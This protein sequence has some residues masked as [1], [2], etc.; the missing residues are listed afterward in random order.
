MGPRRVK[1]EGLS[2]AE[3]V[4]VA[5]VLFSACASC[6]S[7]FWKSAGAIYGGPVGAFGGT[8]L[9]YFFME[10]VENDLT[11]AQVQ[12]NLWE[13]AGAQ[14]AITAT[15]APLLESLWSRVVHLIGWSFAGWLAFYFAKQWWS[16]RRVEIKIQKALGKQPD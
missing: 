14:S 9:G 2:A 11:L 13:M 15:T 5:L 6:Q 3:R 16:K 12:G 7:G 4:F 10:T 8:M 1:R